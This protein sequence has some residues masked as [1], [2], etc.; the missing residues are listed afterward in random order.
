MTLLR[1]LDDFLYR[2][3]THAWPDTKVA[4]YTER[5]VAGHDAA[6]IP[7][8]V[9]RQFE[10]I[11]GKASTLLVHSSMMVAAIGI[12]ATLLAED[13]LQQGIM[14]FEIMLFLV[15]SIVCLRCSSLFREPTEG[16]SA[17]AVHRELILRREMMVSSNT[18]TI[19]LTILV[20]LTLPFVLYL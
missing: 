16:G 19:Y 4:S 13:K 2:R 15:V 6:S 3:V 12:I 9:R 7:P 17:D 20:L 11:D 5:I 18:V 10:L 14:T 8:V 1:R